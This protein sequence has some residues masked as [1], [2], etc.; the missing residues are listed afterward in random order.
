MQPLVQRLE[1]HAS[2]R[3]KFTESAWRALAYS[4]LWS[5]SLYLLFFGDTVNALYQPCHVLIGIR[6]T[7]SAGLCPSAR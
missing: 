4:L 1:I 6:F 5:L 2:E 3:E 7:A